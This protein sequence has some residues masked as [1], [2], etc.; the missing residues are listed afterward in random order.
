MIF[1]PTWSHKDPKVWPQNGTFLKI[2]AVSIIGMKKDVVID[3]GIFSTHVSLWSRTKPICSESVKIFSWFLYIFCSKL[4]VN[5]PNLLEKILIWS[6]LDFSFSQILSKVDQQWIFCINWQ[7][8]L[9]TLL[10]KM[11]PRHQI[12]KLPQKK[13]LKSYLV[14]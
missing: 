14:T 11:P 9:S 3:I 12:R 10:H 4:V 8:L 5:I 7:V 2:L 13:S 1:C 6:F